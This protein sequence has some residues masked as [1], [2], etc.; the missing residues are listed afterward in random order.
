MDRL[1][2]WLQRLSARERRVVTLG[3]IGALLIAVIAVI[4]PLD[5]SVARAA[6]RIER[7]RADLAWMRSVAP[8]LAAAGPSF[9]AGGAGQESLVVVIDRTAR[10]AGL[11]TNLTSSQPSGDG[12]L[13]VRLEGAS[14]DLIAAWLARLADQHGVRVEVATVDGAGEPGLVTAS[15]V[16]RGL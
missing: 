11:G 13:R 7:K 2:E 1:M 16:L 3:A 14:F 9:A 6:E 10:E 15:L 8:E 4:L 5:R 12:G